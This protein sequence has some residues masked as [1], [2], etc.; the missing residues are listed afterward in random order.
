MELAFEQRKADLMRGSA[1]KAH[2]LRQE[3]HLLYGDS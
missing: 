2:E 3:R 1:D